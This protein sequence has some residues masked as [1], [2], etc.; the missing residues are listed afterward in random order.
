MTAIEWL[1][2]AEVA[3]EIRTSVDY[4]SRLCRTGQLPA[5]K[6]GLDWRISRQSLD[7]FMTGERAA[8]P[9]RTRLSAR[10]RRR[11]TT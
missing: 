9:T 10:Q 3:A 7:A 1:T 4:V 5:K 8:A 6:L 11:A 2:T